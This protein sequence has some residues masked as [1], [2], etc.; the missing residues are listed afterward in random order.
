MN[1]NILTAVV[2]L[3]GIAV[4]AVYNWK[5][6]Q[7]NPRTQ[8]RYHQQKWDNWNNNSPRVQP[9][10]PS[11]P[12]P[13]RTRPTPPLSVPTTY[14]EAV[15]IA[16]SQNKKMFLYFGA[17]W[18]HWCKKMESETLSDSR[19]QRALSQYVVYHVDK[20]KESSVARKYNIRG[21]P[22]YVISNGS[23]KVE[24]SSVGYKNPNQFISWLEGR[25][26]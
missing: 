17:E 21:I 10:Q 6:N 18:C 7:A 15:K 1:N 3:L 22:A 2:V 25:A 4:F 23:E 13:P 11:P 9:R 16:K 8:E 5:Q 19:V 14:E 26:F 12:M 24:K 20:S